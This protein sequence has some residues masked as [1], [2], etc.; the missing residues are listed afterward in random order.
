MICFRRKKHLFCLQWRVQSRWIKRVENAGQF[1]H[2]PVQSIPDV[3]IPNPQVVEMNSWIVFAPGVIFQ[4]DAGNR[5]DW[6]FFVWLKTNVT[7]FEELVT[8]PTGQNLEP[9]IKSSNG[10]V[11]LLEDCFIKA[12][13]ICNSE[14]T[15]KSFPGIPFSQGVK[16]HKMAFYGLKV[17]FLASRVLLFATSQTPVLSIPGVMASFASRVN[18]YGNQVPVHLTQKERIPAPPRAVVFSQEELTQKST[19]D[20]GSWRQ[21]GLTG[22]RSI[23]LRACHPVS[24]FECNPLPDSR[25]IW[26]NKKG[27]GKG[28]CLVLQNPSKTVWP[29][30]DSYKPYKLGLNFSGTFQFLDVYHLSVEQIDFTADVLWSCRFAQRAQMVFCCWTFDVFLELKD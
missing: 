17:V 5:S 25:H 23:L 10:A 7:A 6:K 20:R 18:R 16:Q 2:I 28:K 19:Q 22:T 24:L 9:G 27:F 11:V 8:A 15:H 21:K 3:H 1:S 13:V 30:L 4:T 29:R 14:N 26:C 12:P